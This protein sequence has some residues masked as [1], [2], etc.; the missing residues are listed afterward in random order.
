MAQERSLSREYTRQCLH[1]GSGRL[2]EWLKTESGRIS[3]VFFMHG[4]YQIFGASDLLLSTFITFY[5][6]FPLLLSCK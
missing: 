6:D 3:C 1:R 4:Y 2:K 5:I